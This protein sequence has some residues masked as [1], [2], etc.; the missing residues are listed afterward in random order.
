[1]CFGIEDDIGKGEDGVGGEEEEEVFE[2]FGLYVTLSA[3][4]TS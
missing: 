2:C 4:F 3:E 1:V